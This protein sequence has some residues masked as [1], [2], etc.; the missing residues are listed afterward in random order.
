VVLELRYRVYRHVSSS[1]NEKS[2][3]DLSEA[4]SPARLDIAPDKAILAETSLAR[5]NPVFVAAVPGCG[6]RHVSGVGLIDVFLLLVLD[7]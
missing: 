2:P 4:S 7:R 1:L 6:S 5:S 3:G